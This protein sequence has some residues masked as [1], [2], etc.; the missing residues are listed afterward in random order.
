MTKGDDRV[1]TRTE[2]TMSGTKTV[3]AGEDECYCY[4]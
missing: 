2:K 4:S 3:V 1:T